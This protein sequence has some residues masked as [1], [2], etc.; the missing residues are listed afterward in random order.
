MRILFLNPPYL[1]NY[2]RAQRSPAVTKSGTLYYPM[3][4]ALAAGYAEKMGHEIDLI[5]APADCHDL[6]YII[7]RLKEFSPCLVVMD[8]STPSIYNDVKTAEDIKA[9]HPEVFV[10]L[11]GTHVSALPEESKKLSEKVDA[12]AVGEYDKT[13]VAVA[14]AIEGKK[15]LKDIQGLCSGGPDKVFCSGKAELI[16]NL[17]E[18]PHVSGIYKRFLSVENY[19]NPNALFPMV[20]ISSSRGCP[21][22]C[23]FCVYPQTMMGQRMR[24]RSNEDVLSEIEYIVKNFP[25][26]KAI[27][28][29]DD[30]FPGIKKRCI[31][32]CEEMIERGITI[33]WTANARAD[34]DYETM[35][36]MKASGCRSLCVGFESGSQLLLDNIK[37]R[38]KVENMQRFSDDAKRAGILIHGCFMVG[39]PGETK[40]TMNQTLELAKRLNPDTIQVYPI[41]VYPGTE[42]Y[43]WFNERGFIIT[44]DFSKWLTPSGLHNAV[45]RTECLGPDELVSFCDT[46]R[47]EFYLRPSYILYKLKQ[48]ITH[49]EEIKRT[50]KSA[51]TFMKYLI[52]GSDISKDNC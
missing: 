39:L 52:K 10:L 50:L 43:E 9:A 14:E 17:D 34:L 21:F 48:M 23:T 11:V 24:V 32:M 16:E 31:E 36:T 12:V 3:W 47:R 28:F 13:V 5:D 37:K 8:T 2:S 38:T 44:D 42:A 29:E 26:I 19:F 35:K 20:M 27:F 33:S 51:K 41:M 25:D 30:T 15:E 49:Q 45:I 1:K 40:E 46:A 6:G 18:I 4:L 22:N 7:K